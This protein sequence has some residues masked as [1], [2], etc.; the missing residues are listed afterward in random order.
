MIG[1]IDEM[2]EKYDRDSNGLDFLE[3]YEASGG[4]LEDL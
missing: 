2:I 1:A 4:S 3:M